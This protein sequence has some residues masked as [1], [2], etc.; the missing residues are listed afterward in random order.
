MEAIMSPAMSK[1]TLLRK[2][3]ARNRKIDTRNAWISGAWYI[4]RI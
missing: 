2:E 3:A 4:L 1:L